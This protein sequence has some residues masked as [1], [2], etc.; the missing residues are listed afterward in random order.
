MAGSFESQR[1]AAD[2]VALRLTCDCASCM[3]EGSM[4]LRLLWVRRLCAMGLLPWAAACAVSRDTPALTSPA[5]SCGAAQRLANA[6]GTG[7]DS[8]DDGD[9]AFMQYA[10]AVDA[11]L[12]SCDAEVRTMSA[13][14][15]DDWKIQAF[16]ARRELEELARNR[17]DRDLRAAHRRRISRMLR[18][19]AGMF[20]NPP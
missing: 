19:Y 12:R 14:L 4:P 20:G 1:S 10:A 2:Q 18:L 13:G 5:V 15:A 16:L 6:A 3:T 17:T 11:L 7:M 9:G 8:A